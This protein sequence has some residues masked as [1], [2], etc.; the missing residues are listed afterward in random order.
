MQKIII[1]KLNLECVKHR[2]PIKCNHRT[3]KWTDFE[4]GEMIKHYSAEVKR[5]KMEKG[6]GK[7]EETGD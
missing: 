6:H 3:R 7:A 1:N 4:L 2:T 5:L